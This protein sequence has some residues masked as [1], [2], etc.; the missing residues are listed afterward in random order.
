ME[1]G[2][3]GTMLDT[4]LDTTTDLDF[5]DELFLDGCWLET[6]DGSE[7]LHQSPSRSGALLDP[8]LLWPALETDGNLSVS[9][10]QKGSQDE[11]QRPSSD[12]S[13]ERSL[14]NAISLGQNTI[15]LAGCCSVSESN[16]IEGS[17][18]G[19]RLW[20]APWGNPGSTSSVT[21]RL[22]KAIGY[23]RDVTIDKDV[24]IQI[25]VPVS[26]GGK[27]IL[28]TSNQPFSLG[29]SCPSIARYREISENFVFSADKDSKDLAGLPGRVF[30]D[31]VPEWT[32]DVRFFRSDEYPRVDQA[33]LYDI[34]GTLALPIFEQGSRTCLGVIEVVMT[35][36][37]IKYHPEL[38][39]VCKAL[40]VRVLCLF[41][42]ILCSCVG[43][44]LS[45]LLKTIN[46]IKITSIFLLALANLL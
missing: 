2:V 43:S 45:L 15:T 26:R 30:L 13:Q 19:T 31:K 42:R 16:V 33:Q 8:L 9:P 20:I 36:Q 25:W 21:D 11:M 46:G 17:E 18:L 37:Q 38:E 6:I 23:I 35:K 44:S 4:L 40:E 41:F 7:F 32:P 27:R 24:L 10:S 29:S 12:E 22:I 14:V 34:C 28:T 3:S 1:D 39:S 5:M